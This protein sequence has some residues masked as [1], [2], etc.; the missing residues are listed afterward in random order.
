MPVY[1]RTNRKLF[2][3]QLAPELS[4]ARLASDV[5]GQRFPVARREQIDSEGVPRTLRKHH[6]IGKSENRHEH[7]GTFLRQHSGDPATKV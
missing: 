2:V 1:T 3:R 7:I 6:H 5:F 4:V